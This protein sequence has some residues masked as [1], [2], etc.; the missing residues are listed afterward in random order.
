MYATIDLDRILVEDKNIA[1][2]IKIQLEG[3]LDETD[4]KKSNKRNFCAILEIGY[5]D[6]PD[7]K[8]TKNHHGTALY[9]VVVENCVR[10]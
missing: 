10:L 1:N 9:F 2:E 3:I 6:R 5:F 8:Y 7:N 4:R